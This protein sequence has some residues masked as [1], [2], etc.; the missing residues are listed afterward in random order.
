MK[1]MELGT[2]SVESLGALIVHS[3][4]LLAK[5]AQVDRGRRLVLRP[6]GLPSGLIVPLVDR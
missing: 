1:T 3:E 6:E 4:D 5:L 2:K